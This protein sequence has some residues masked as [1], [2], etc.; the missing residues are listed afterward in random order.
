MALAD[1]GAAAQG[2]LQEMIKRRLLE[3]A[4][5]QQAQLE[6]QRESRA[7]R[8]LGLQEAQFDE[9]AG[10]NRRLDEASAAKQAFEEGNVLANQVPEGA[11]IPETDPNAQKL[12]GFLRTRVE[13]RAAV[14]E[15]FVGPL[16]AATG[17]TQAQA[18]QERPGGFIR[19]GRT[20]AQQQ[21]QDQLAAAQAQ[22]DQAQANADRSFEQS[23]F[24][25]DRS[26]GLQAGA[27]ARAAEKQATDM[28]TKDRALKA[29]RESIQTRITDQIGLI[30]Q[31][32]QPL[33]DPTKA[34]TLKSGVEPLFGVGGPAASKA[35][36]YGIGFG[37]TR[38][39]QA[40]LSRLESS[41]I[42]DLIAEMKAQSPTG[43]TGFGQLNREE[44]NVL[45]NGAVQLQRAQ[46][47]EQAAKVLSG[48]RSALGKLLTGGQMAPGETT[49]LDPN[50]LGAVP[51]ASGDRA[52]E[53]LR[54]YGGM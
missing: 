4:A 10:R 9:T 53:L 11:F 1:A 13:P 8:S 22:R 25:A 33:A 19:T 39:A 28:A 21:T 35:A 3:Q 45:T 29:Q 43:A 47:E 16:Q 49:T 44:L 2:A 38:D 51:G 7:E 40:V 36:K 27:Q 15:D 54:K 30:D 17:E 6:A 14:G 5:Q 37:A 34:P 32:L 23:K 31:L 42:I 48:M 50:N 18:R 24:N 46:T 20:F 41:K 12:P 52:D 26:F